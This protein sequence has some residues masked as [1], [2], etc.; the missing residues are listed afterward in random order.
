MDHRLFSLD[1]MGLE[2]AL[3][4]RDFGKRLAYDAERHTLAFCRSP[5]QG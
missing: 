4:Q 1:S 5:C 2:N 3:L